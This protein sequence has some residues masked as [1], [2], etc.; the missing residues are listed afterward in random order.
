MNQPTQELHLALEDPTVSGTFRRYCG[1][2]AFSQVAV[3]VRGAWRQFDVSDLGTTASMS[4]SVAA[5]PRRVYFVVMG[6]S[7]SLALL[8]LLLA[9]PAS[10]S[11]LDPG[12]TVGGAG[13]KWTS[14]DLLTQTGENCSVLGNSY[15]EPMISGIASYGG[16]AGVPVV[17][18][19]YYTAFLVS[20]PGNPCG[21]G[22]SAVETDVVLPPNTTIDTSAPIR[23]FGE[24]SGAST[25]GD[26]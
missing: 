10:A 2:S 23:C 14:G 1:T 7:I 25:F 22:S 4:R 3:S 8:L 12:Q 18:Q 9:V 26:C 5:E 6:R 16:T 24:P 11:A 13:S 21:P 19:R 20:V 15:T 17:N